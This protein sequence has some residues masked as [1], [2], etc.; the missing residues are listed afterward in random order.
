MLLAGGRVVQNSSN[1]IDNREEMW[2]TNDIKGFTIKIFN[3]A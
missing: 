2:Q 1:K 3:E